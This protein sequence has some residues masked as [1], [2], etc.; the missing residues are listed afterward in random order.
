LTTESTLAAV[1]GKE[2]EGAD[3]ASGATAAEPDGCGA[4]VESLA[5]RQAVASPIAATE[6]AIRV[7]GVCIVDRCSKRR[8]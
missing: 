8:A 2:V 4:G 3:D 1:M 5:V 6:M 7:R